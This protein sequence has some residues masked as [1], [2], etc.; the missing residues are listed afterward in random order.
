V[1]DKTKNI[2]IFCVNLLTVLMLSGIAAAADPILTA[3]YSDRSVINSGDFITIYAVYTLGDNEYNYSWVSVD[4]VSDSGVTV[5]GSVYPAD[6]HNST[7]SAVSLYYRWGLVGNY[8]FICYLNVLDVTV[9]RPG[10]N[11]FRVESSEWPISVP[12]YPHELFPFVIIFGA[13]SITILATSK[14]GWVE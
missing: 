5:I 10:D 13:V 11:T 9:S 7:N 6:T 2:I 12:E 1:Q 3:C 8:S 14:Q 4:V